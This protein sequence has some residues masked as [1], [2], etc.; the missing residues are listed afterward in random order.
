MNQI[1]ALLS[2]AELNT[3]ANTQVLVAVLIALVV[4][5]L[6]SP[7][8][9]LFN[10]FSIVLDVGYKVTSLIVAAIRKAR[11]KPYMGASAGGS[12]QA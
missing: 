3:Y 1:H 2:N 7:I 8:I 6:V 12:G 5:R 11:Y 10:P 4:Y 9:D